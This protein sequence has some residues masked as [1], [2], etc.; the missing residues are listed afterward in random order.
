MQGDSNL[1]FSAFKPYNRQW[2]A[3]SLEKASNIADA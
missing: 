2:W 3:A 1:N